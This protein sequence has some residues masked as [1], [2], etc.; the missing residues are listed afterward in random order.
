MLHDHE[1]LAAEFA[2]EI[3]NG[4]KT[5]HLW[6]ALVDIGYEMSRSTVERHIAG[7]CSCE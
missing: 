2:T 3:L 1:G 6:R 4:A 5:S 7:E